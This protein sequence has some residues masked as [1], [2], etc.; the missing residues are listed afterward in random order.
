MCQFTPFYAWRCTLMQPFQL[1]DGWREQMLGM[2]GYY[3]LQVTC[4]RLRADQFVLTVWSC[5]H[6]QHLMPRWILRMCLY[7]VARKCREAG[8]TQNNLTGHR[9]LIHTYAIPVSKDMLLCASPDPPC[10]LKMLWPWACAERSVTFTTR[11]WAQM[12]VVKSKWVYSK[13]KQWQ[14]C[15]IQCCLKTTSFYTVFIQLKDMRQGE[16]ASMAPSKATVMVTTGTGQEIVPR[17]TH[18]SFCTD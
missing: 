3:R 2:L 11:I 16:T 10:I 13:S 14:L 17:I 7:I 9:N 6:M 12:A 5:T 18:C 15:I 8:V 4:E 1:T